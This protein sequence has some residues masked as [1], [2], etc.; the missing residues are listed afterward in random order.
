[1][2]SRNLMVMALAVITLII[3]SACRP[4]ED[5]HLLVTTGRETY[6]KGECISVQVT[7]QNRGSDNLLIQTRMAVDFLAEIPAF[8]DVGFVITSPSGR[9]IEFDQLTRVR[10]VNLE[11][12]KVLDAGKTYPLEHPLEYPITSFYAPFDEAGTYSVQAIYENKRDPG[13]GRSAWKGRITSNTV[14]FTLEP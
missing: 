3:V 14:T 8:G 12:F 11:D 4:Q 5:L 13:D 7:L 1:M 6:L 10:M 2:K 9:V